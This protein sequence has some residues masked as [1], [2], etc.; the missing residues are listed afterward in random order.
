MFAGPAG[1]GRPERPGAAHPL[2]RRRVPEQASCPP[3]HAK[4]LEPALLEW[5]L[6]HRGVHAVYPHRRFV[7]AEVR[8]F[9][10]FLRAELGDGSRDPGWPAG[11]PV[12]GSVASTQ[13]AARSRR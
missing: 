9:V 12:P 11:I 3:D 2:D 8:A 7:P 1:A 5:S 6:G 4:R 13:P 10:D